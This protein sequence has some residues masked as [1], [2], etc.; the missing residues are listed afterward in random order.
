[1]SANGNN[2]TRISNTALRYNEQPSWSPDGTRI[3][4]TDNGNDIYVMNV[5]GSNRRKLTTNAANDFNPAWSPDGQKIAFASRRDAVGSDGNSE[6]YVMDA[7]TGNNQTRLTNLPGY[8]SSPTWSPDG[9]KIAFSRSAFANALI[10]FGNP[11]SGIYVMNADGSSRARVT[12]F[13]TDMAPDWGA[14]F[15]AVTPAGANVAVQLGDTN[16]TFSNI[17]SPGVTS[18]DT[19][20]PVAAGPLPAGYTTIPGLG[21]AFDITS[22]AT[23][24]GPITACFKA[25]SVTNATEF[26]AL[27]ILHGENGV[28]VDRTVL[29]PNS[30]APN[31]ATRTICARID[32]LSPFTIALATDQT[33]PSI[34]G[35]VVDANGIGIS[36]VALTLSGAQTRVT[37]TDSEGNFGFPNLA[38]GGDYTV[39]ASDAG[40]MFSPQNENFFSLDEDKAVLFTA[41]Q[42]PAAPASAV[43]FASLADSVSEGSGSIEVAIVRLGSDADIVTVDYDTTDVTASQA[44][45]YTSISGT[46]TFAPGETVK[47]FSVPITDD[48]FVEGNEQFRITLSGVTGNAAPVNSTTAVITIADNDTT[49]PTTNPMDDA[50]TFVRQHYHDLLGR[51]PDP[52]G[53][54]YWT[55]QI[56]QCGSDPSCARARRIDVSNAFFFELEFQQTGAYVFRL[57]R[58]AYGNTQPL[59][60]PDSSNAAEAHKIPSYGIFSRDRARVVGGIDLAESQ[61]ALANAFAQRP[62][63]LAKYPANLD[64]PGFVDAVL[65]AIKTDSGADLT[66]QRT[67][68]ITLSSSGGRGAVLY[69]LADDNA[70]TNP[71]NNR[72]FI[73]SEYNRA[74]VSTQ[75]FGFLRR[76]AD[77]GGLL[78]WLNQV[79]RFP[80]RDVGIQHAIVCSFITSKEYQSRFSS[81][82]THTN[83][84]CPQ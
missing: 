53:L 33:Q 81:V 4:F 45:D 23:F 78:F 60:N 44:T 8:D 15:S 35:R 46:L 42:A 61:L 64:G 31:F 57:Y 62:E 19:I 63:F 84:E 41:T 52:D 37:E 80:V 49:P 21:M 6:I 11:G 28:L 48:N 75:Y 2:K 27:R 38:A 22:T 76:D 72:A 5:D 58:A 24:S 30:P 50:S 16:I 65:N 74:F 13:S 3:A 25:A 10:S 71:I 29:P 68:L 69:R 43:G 56:M 66:S 7:L 82:V 83:A 54:A 12:L 55:S 67:A 34:G 18:V 20:A 39:V 40:F 79:N 77:I 51:E 73:D 9:T 14:Q 36:G 17:S 32:S 1:M 47:T 70:Q 26:A 59:P